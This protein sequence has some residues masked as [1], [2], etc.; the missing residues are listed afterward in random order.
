[1]DSL[2]ILA[3]FRPRG[4]VAASLVGLVLV[5]LAGCSSRPARILP[6]S[7]DPDSAAQLAI[8]AYDA[9]GDGAL[10]SD[11]L[12]KCPGILAAVA[13]YDT[14]G[15]GQVTP[16]EIAARIRQWTE[17]GTGLVAVV[18]TVQMDGEPL[19][20]AEVRFVPEGF[21]GE[22]VKP[23]HGKTS[24]RGRAIMAMSPEDLPAGRERLQVMQM[25]VYRVEITH[26]DVEIPARYN[27]QTEL[28]V[29]MSQGEA[30]G[31]VHLQLNSQ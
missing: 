8:E 28:G 14:S 10:S 27:T 11:E 31:G 13:R 5:V 6:P 25:A 29:D 17:E 30:Q 18:C 24:G 19:A 12:K 16:D 7:I 3:I 1:M 2:S 23:A 4:E 26:P 22:A 21:L 20:G 9:D 15:D